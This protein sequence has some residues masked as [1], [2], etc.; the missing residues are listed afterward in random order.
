MNIEF[1]WN[2]KAYS[3]TIEGN[4]EL[5]ELTPDLVRTSMN[6]AVGK[7]AYY[8]SLLS[9]AKR[10]QSAIETDFSEQES[11]WY[12]KIDAE[13]GKRTEGWKKAKIIVDNAVQWKDWQARSRK[14]DYV[15]S[16]VKGIM[17][18]FE[19]QIK[20]LMTISAM[21]RVEMEHSF[22]GATAEAMGKRSLHDADDNF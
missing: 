19:M 22:A 1:T 10:M 3:E 12:L 6:R 17:S 2:D 4:L 7:L 13:E 5:S 11:R 8:G 21:M 9:D 20:V 16:Q 15:I 14:V 18:A